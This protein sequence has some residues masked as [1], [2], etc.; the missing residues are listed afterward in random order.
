MSHQKDNENQIS[1]T[2]PGQSWPLWVQVG[3]S[4]IPYA[5]G[6]L[7][8][9]F[10]ETRQKKV[11]ERLEYYF[12]YI[13]NEIKKIDVLKLDKS[14]LKSD[15]FGELFARGAEE[16]ARSTT[17]QRIRRF[18]NIIIKNSL[19][20]K[21]SRERSSGLFTIFNRLSDLDAFVLL[22]FGPPYQESF[23]TESRAET[24]QLVRT[25]A[26]YLA[27][28][29]PSDQNIEDSLIYMDNLGVTW[30]SQRDNP[31][32]SPESTRQV[33]EFSVFRPPLG[34]L[35]VDAI[36]PPGFFTDQE[37]IDSNSEWPQKFI[38]REYYDEIFSNMENTEN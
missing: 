19:A 6:P 27:V 9:Y 25:L 4:A 38:S 37:L 13:T 32:W 23:K 10:V 33:R 14:Y 35:V 2:Q 5:G 31:R 8:T 15:E 1:L 11:Q 7:S 3:L 34:D 30:V 16:A 29:L 12:S 22:C 18:A 20:S 17:K 21:E 28:E 24:I 36:T 26:N